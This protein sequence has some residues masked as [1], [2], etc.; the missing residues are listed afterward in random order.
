M[1]TRSVFRLKRFMNISKRIEKK[2]K[3]EVHQKDKNTKYLTKYIKTHKRRTGRNAIDKRVFEAELLL[4]KLTGINIK[5]TLSNGDCFYSAIY[6]SLEERELV[7]KV[8]ACLNI[9]DKSEKDFIQT[10]RNKVSDWIRSGNLPSNDPEG[11]VDL[12]DGLQFAIASGNYSAIVEGYPNWFVKLFGSN[13]QDIGSRE[14]FTELLAQQVEKSGNWVGEI[15]VKIVAPMLLKCDVILKIHNSTNTEGF[16]IKEGIK[17]IIH[18]YNQG[19]AHYE[20]FSFSDTSNN[21]VDYV[22][23]NNQANESPV[24]SPAVAL[25]ALVEPETEDK[26]NPEITQEDLDILIKTKEHEL[27]VCRQHCETIAKELRQYQTKSIGKTAAE[28]GFDTDATLED[29]LVHRVLDPADDWKEKIEF[30][31]NIPNSLEKPVKLKG[32][33]YFEALFH[34]LFAINWYPELKT[35]H[36]DFFS[37]KKYT[38]TSSPKK[39]YLYTTTILSAGGGD[40]IQGISDITFKVSNHD[41]TKED[42]NTDYTCGQIYKDKV[43]ETDVFYFFSIKGFRKEK[44]IKDSYDIPILYQQ[45]DALK[46]IKNK[47]LC[48][49]IRNKDDFIKHLN[50]SKITF[51]KESLSII[52]GYEELM[53]YFHDFRKTFFKLYGKLESIEDRKACVRTMFPENN[54]IRPP[55]NLFYHQ[56]LIVNSVIQSIT[57]VSERINPHFICIGVLPRGG[58]SYIAGG[59]IRDYRLRTKKE[60]F[61]VLFLTSAVNET[62]SQF[63]DDLVDK[64]GEFRDIKFVDARK[65]TI[66]KNNFVFISRQLSASKSSEDGEK[67]VN[68]MFEVLKSKDINLEYDLVFFDEAHVGILTELQQTNLKRAFNKFKIP[69]I[70]MTA[71]Y[72]KPSN[73][74]D[75]NKDL[76]VWDLFDINDMKKLDMLG[77]ENFTNTNIYNRYGK[78]SIDILQKFLDSGETLESISKPY[79]KFPIPVFIHPTFSEKTLEK[80]QHF[81]YTRFFKMNLDKE[82]MKCLENI[83]DD[84]KTDICKWK[85][86]HNY[87]QYRDQALILRNYLTPKDD[88]LSELGIINEN[89]KAMIQIFKKAYKENTRPVIGSPFSV[90]MFLPSLTDNPVGHLCRVWGSFLMDTKFWSTHFV[91]L[92]L[93]PLSD[94]Y[95]EKEATDKKEKRQELH[96][97]KNGFCVREIINERDLKKKIQLVEKEALKEGKGLLM[98]TGEVAKMGISLPCTDVVFLFS[99]NDDSADDIIQKMF[100][101]LTDS[102]NKKFGFI[103]DLNIKRIIKALFEYDLAKDKIKLNP[104]MKTKDDRLNDIFE[105]CDFGYDSFIENNSGSMNYEEMM[106]TIKLKIFSNLELLNVTARAIQQTAYHELLKDVDISSELFKFLNKKGKTKPKSIKEILAQK[107]LNI[108]GPLPKSKNVLNETSD[109][110][111]AGS[112]QEHEHIEQAK[113]EAQEEADKKNIENNFKS[114]LITFL[115]SL[116]IRNDSIVWNK[117]VSINELLDIFKQDKQLVSKIK[118][119]CEG[120]PECLHEHSNLYERVYCDVKSYTIDQ[121]EENIK[122]LIDLIYNFLSSE[123]H[124]TLLYT[125]QSYIDAFIDEIQNKPKLKGGKR[126]TLKKKHSSI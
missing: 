12:Y 21:E 8:A 80:L 54:E 122:K 38:E 125:L 114:L 42:N 59:I 109:K 67:I 44:G 16:E 60:T 121:S 116:I 110:N 71:T 91:A 48:V 10:F 113:K 126:R 27:T 74:L 39:N 111:M 77:L 32:G 76:L 102:N 40:E 26:Y 75:S 2:Y 94:T 95:K 28:I 106:K 112:E 73:L 101:S 105:T 51:L 50:R 30:L 17:D 78:L 4:S 118:C 14:T 81:D 85:S 49:G 104:I 58:K 107:G 117:G 68:D 24:T 7:S 5:K 33:S 97:W 103:V 18:L 15:E 45:T 13:G 92:T 100:R 82:R 53:D 69:I 65:D 29:L 64:F 90:L 88:E 20:Y 43:N 108:P 6:R 62:I 23:N 61:N 119:D 115:N 19:E 87:L 57:T 123:K 120:K 86:W 11:R 47:R 99:T 25:V 9:S 72:I 63:K 41:G 52:I 1:D 37:I 3:D 83:Q 79:K 98:L 46:L 84:G 36:L 89:S 93:S 96:C 31:I 35:K 70:M 66:G 56:E 55:L 34:L 124:T 22:G